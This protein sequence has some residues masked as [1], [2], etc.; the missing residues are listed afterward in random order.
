[1]SRQQFSQQTRKATKTSLATLRWR[2]ATVEQ[3]RIRSIVRNRPK[4]TPTTETTKQCRAQINNLKVSKR[5]KH[6]AHL[7]GIV[8]SLNDG[9]DT[10]RIYMNANIRR[11]QRTMSNYHLKPLPERPTSLS[12]VTSLTKGNPDC[13][14]NVAAT[15]MQHK[16]VI[17]ITNCFRIYLF[18]QCHVHL[19]TRLKHVA[20]DSNDEPTHISHTRASSIAIHHHNVAKQTPYR[21]LLVQQTFCKFASA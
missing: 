10:S 17:V 16:I 18:C 13:S 8:E 20:F 19:P 11:Q 7:A 14:A 6:N 9:I 1:M 4:P 2:S 21:I 3:A 15:A 5:L 12:G